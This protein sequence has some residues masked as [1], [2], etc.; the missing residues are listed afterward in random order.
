MTPFSITNDLILGIFGSVLQGVILGIALVVM[1]HLLLKKI[2]R[3]N[4]STRFAL[5]FACLII[6]N[7]TV[8]L[9]LTGNKEMPALPEQVRVPRLAAQATA[10]S[11]VPASRE[12]PADTFVPAPAPAFYLTVPVGPELPTVLTLFYVLIV[13]CLGMRLF[14]SYWRLKRLRRRS[15]P[16]PP[17]LAARLPEWLRLSG[18]RR[19]VTLLLTGDTAGPFAAGFLRPAVIVPESLLLQITSEELESIV[20]HELSHLRRYDDWTTLVQ[21]VLRMFLFFHPGVHWVCRELEFDR[22]VACDDSVLAATQSPK[23]Y[24][25]SLTKVAEAAQW[26]RGPILASGAVFRKSHIS[27][28]IELLLNAAR[29]RRPRV[30]GVSF[31]LVA[32]VV[33]GIAS[34]F[35]NLPAFVSMVEGGNYYRSRWTTDGRTVQLEMAGEVEFGEDDVT[36]IHMSPNALLRVEERTGWSGRKAEVRNG[37]SGKPEVR[38]YLHGREHPLD[39]PARAWLASTLL[40][41]IRDSGIN[42]EERA[43][44]ILDRGGPTALLQEIDRISS[45]HS[46]RRYLLTAMQSG[47]LQIDDM[48]RALRSAS[49]M[50]SDNEKANLLIEISAD[51][52]TPD[53]RASFFDAVDTIG[54]DHDRRR[55]ISKAVAEAGRDPE[56]MALAARAA[57]RMSSD[58]DKAEALKQMPLEALLPEA[59]TRQPLLRAAAS[60]QSDHDRS[61]LLGR[62]LETPSVDGAAAAEILHIAEGIQSDSDKARLLGEV[63]SEWLGSAPAKEAWF[64]AVRSIHSDADRARVLI[65]YLVRGEAT[66][67]SLAQ[68]CQSTIGIGSD[69]DKASVLA[70]AHSALPPQ[71]FAAVRSIVSDSDKR[72]VLERVLV[73]GA[74]PEIAAAAVEA[75]GTLS[76]DH[77]KAEVLICAARRY[78]DDGTRA[79]IRKVAAGVASDSDYRRVTSKL[80]DRTP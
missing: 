54:S 1:A 53:L 16:A 34:D 68:I 79:L 6:L 70:A 60:I 42:A 38:Y 62:I 23:P 55:V 63:R 15:R 2:L 32:L 31:A 11:E 20:V 41:V 59:R 17:E 71:C 19:D 5:W 50:S 36:V 48:R 75:A 57:E 40:R 26:R 80:L 43:I 25:R 33:I 29:D 67:D 14:L 56:T 58:H 39:E 76:S 18:C 3:L 78:S 69:H 72:R 74:S 27:R 46:R 77:D 64:I 4:A 12:A 7:V 45:D 44:R 22:E 47:K 61:G 35:A 13:T 30:S 28:R 73:S 21:R 66:P 8:F 9:P 24:A 51:G 10:S 65:G 37:E 52:L 49:R